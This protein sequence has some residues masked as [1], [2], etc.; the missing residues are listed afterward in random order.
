MADRVEV[1]VL[2]PRHKLR[3]F[4]LKVS[5]E[6]VHLNLS[7]LDPYRIRKITLMW[8]QMQ[9]QMPAFNLKL[10]K[11]PLKL[12]CCTTSSISVLYTPHQS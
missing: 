3:E 1:E 12:V 11:W 10:C 9:K 2:F 8:Y 6:A 4:F 5:F 7:V